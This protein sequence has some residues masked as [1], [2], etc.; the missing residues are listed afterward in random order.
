MPKNLPMLSQHKK[1]GMKRWRKA[2][3]YWKYLLL[4]WYCFLLST[5]TAMASNV[6]DFVVWDG[7]LY[8]YTGTDSVVE[9]P[10]NLGITKIGPYAFCDYNNF[11]TTVEIPD[12][13]TEI[14]ER[15][16]L[17]C[18]SLK[19][20]TYLIR[21][22]Y[23]WYACFTGTAISNPIIVNNGKTLCYVPTNYQ[24]LYHTFYGYGN[25]G[26]RFLWLFGISS[27]KIPDR[28]TK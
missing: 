16:F 5:T 25:S 13:V 15:A 19:S 28:I 9:I 7:I 23:C 14:G 21:C 18:T 12:G 27:L 10:A 26:R 1:K 8:D 17:Y 3:I 2:W 11:I 22:Y 4:Y 20:A 24:N 6:V